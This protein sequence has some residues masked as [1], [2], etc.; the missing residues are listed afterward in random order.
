MTSFAACGG[1]DSASDDQTNESSPVV[2]ETVEDFGTRLSDAADAA[3]AGDCDTVDEFND[4]AGFVLPCDSSGAGYDDFEVTATDD[5]ETAGLVDF[6]DKEVPDGATAI[7]AIN[8][9]GHFRLMQSFVPSSLGLEA[10]QVGT[11]PEETEVRDRAVESFVTA[12][13][14]GD[15]DTYFQ[16]GLTPTQNKEKECR[17]EFSEKTGIKPDLE[18]NPDATA[19]LLGESEAFGLYELETPD[20]YRVVLALRNYADGDEPTPDDGYRILTYRAQD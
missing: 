18:A 16:L 12:V 15:C 8:A 13:R 9:D 17:I 1:D 10:K 20:F 4:E 7:A 3:A 5:F 14:E 6:T 2:T 11:E 19:V